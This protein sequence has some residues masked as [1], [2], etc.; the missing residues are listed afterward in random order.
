MQNFKVIIVEDVPLELKGTVG[1]VKNDI[2]EAEIIGTAENEA[3]YWRLLKQQVP[4]LVLL[5]LGLGGSTTVGVELCRQTKEM[6]PQVRV[7][8]FTG[9]ILNEAE[10]LVE[11]GVPAETEIEEVVVKRKKAKGK[12]SANL[13]GIE[14]EVIDHECSKEVL[15]EKFPKGWKS[16]PDVVYSELKYIPA[17]FKVLEHHIKVYAGKRETD[18]V[19]RADAPDRLL[20]HSIVTPELAAAVINAK[21]VNGI[22]LNRLSEEFLRIGVNIPRQDM[23]GWMIRLNAYYLKQIHARMKEEI[24]RS[25][26][27]HCDETPFIMPKDGKEYMWVF[28]SPGGKDAHPVFLYEYLG[29]RN[30]KVISDYLSGYKGYL[31]TDG[32]QPYH[33]LDKKSEE[34][35][36][37]GCW[38]HCRRKYADIIKAAE[39]GVSFTPAQEIAAEAVKRIDTIYHLDNKYKDSSDEDRLKNR[40]DVIKP[41]VDDFFVWIKEQTKKTIANDSLKS[42]LNYAA[43]QE[44]YLR[45]FLEDAQIPLDNND[46]ERSIKQF[47]VGKKNWQIIASMN[48]ARASAMLYSI[49][50]SAKANGLNPYEYFSHM[51]TELAKYPRNGA[52]EEVVEELMPWSDK[53]PDKV[54][55]TQT[56]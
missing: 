2:P 7:L 42:A 39:K 35:S 19:L 38:S 22:P 27:V 20:A 32:Y 37:S 53:L 4:D 55:K 26:H 36:V 41:L 28:H 6:H 21:Y 9:E 48:G 13:E 24:M 5:D 50:E 31:I 30:G 8:I 10:E 43:N 56:R 15:D 12:R 1:I 40:E 33:T 25:H 44:K 51:F 34:I 29:G 45:V 11:Q 23:A 16:L 47:C 14:V 52:P 17:T 54:R 18:G 3:A 46:A 49:A